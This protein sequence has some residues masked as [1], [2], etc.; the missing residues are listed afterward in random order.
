MHCLNLPLDYANK[1]D[2][3]NDYSRTEQIEILGF[4]KRFLEDLDILVESFRPGGFK[5]NDYYYD[6]LKEVGYRFSS[7]L[8]KD[9]APN[10]NLVTGE[11][12]Q[13]FDTNHNGIVEFPVTS[14][15]LNSV[16][17]G[18]EII[19]LSP[20]FFEVESVYS[21]IKRLEKIVLNFHSFS[22]YHS[23]PVREVFQNRRK[24]SLKHMIREFIIK[25][26]AHRFQSDILTETIY[27]ESLNNWVSTL[28][29]KAEFKWI[30]E[31]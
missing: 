9:I 17:G 26:L 22:L 14:V 20:D 15:Y 27:Q 24:E 3:F 23:R 25:K 19:N 5:Q 11:I 16:K 8:S 29:D 28:E 12:N 6:V 10:I 1:S 2:Y 4:G 31:I 7:T 13:T 18:H 30:G 21:E